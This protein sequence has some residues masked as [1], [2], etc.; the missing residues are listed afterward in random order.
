MS[1]II[2]IEEWLYHTL[3]Q[4]SVLTGLLGGTAIYSYQAPQNVQMPYIVFGLQSAFDEFAMDGSRAAVYGVYRILAI[5]AGESFYS[6]NPIMTRVD[7]LI[8]AKQ[9]TVLSSGR[10]IINAERVESLAY[11]DTHNGVRINYLGG[12][13]RVWL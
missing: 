13:Y 12:L 6:L 11:T 1:E 8:N 3:S 9:G 5:N 4:D 7:S 2:E 10:K